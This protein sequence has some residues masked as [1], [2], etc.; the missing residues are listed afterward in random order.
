M[1][2]AIRTAAFATSILMTALL[3]ACGGGGGASSG[4]T[5]TSTTTVPSGTTLTTSQYA[6][7]SVEAAMFSAINADRQM[8]GFPVYQEN[9]LLDQAAQNHTVYMLDNGGTITDFETQGNPG[10]TGVTGQDRAE[11]VGWPTGVSTG[12]GSAG[13]YT[14]ATLTSTQYGDALVAAW[15]SGVYHQSLLVD[16][17]SL[18]GLGVSQTTYNGYPQLAASLMIGEFVNT[19][20]A[21]ASPMTFPCQGATGLPYENGGGETPTAPGVTGAFGTPVSIVGN[22]SDVIR[23]SSGSMIDLANSASVPLQ[24]LDSSTDPNHVLPAY[25]GVVY[26]TSPLTANTQYSVTISGTVNGT[27]FSRNFTFTTGSTV[28]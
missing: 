3:A 11:Y 24:A 27:P 23:I 5:T 26:P 8:C 22:P 6:S 21:S 10:F 7:G 2:Q 13:Y 16:P 1:K 14:N 15:A 9:T 4:S 12:T 17:M 18:T 20:S 28:G 25:V 19:M